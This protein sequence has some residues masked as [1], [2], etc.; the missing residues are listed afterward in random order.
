M[1]LNR[2]KIKH[3]K[4]KISARGSKRKK[5]KPASEKNAIQ[6]VERFKKKNR[7]LKIS[8]KQKNVDKASY[9]PLSK[10]KNI[11]E[12]HTVFILGNA[13]G[14]ERQN[15]SLLDPYF[16]IGINRIFYIYDPTILMWQD[17]QVWT[18]DKKTILKQEAIK[19]CGHRGGPRN[20]FLNFG[21]KIRPYRFGGDLE[22]LYGTG[23]TTALAAQFAVA[24]G[25]SNI[26][27]LGTD[28]AY[29]HK[30]KTDFYGKNKDHKP[31]TLKMC[32]GAMQWLKDDCPVKIYNCSGNKLWKTKKL[33]KVINEIKPLQLSRKAYRKIFSK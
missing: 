14:I 31:Y 33:E 5:T 32:N 29:G 12:G 7:K 22:T 10:W 23:N 3:T 13:P 4:L 18:S 19:V 16:T 15:L 24:L 9:I 28:C 26:V 6:Y 25:C 1:H 20:K 27:L 8:S 2:K 30:G 11:L 21:V 17:K